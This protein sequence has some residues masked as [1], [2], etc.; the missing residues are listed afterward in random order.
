MGF[1][2]E[3]KRTVG[4][5]E[6]N[7]KFRVYKQ[8][9]ISFLLSSQITVCSIIVLGLIIKW[10]LY[11]SFSKPFNAYFYRIANSTLQADS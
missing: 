10:L 9:F 6:N 2:Q 8:K 5:P 7:K 1:K 4:H 3:G 11:F